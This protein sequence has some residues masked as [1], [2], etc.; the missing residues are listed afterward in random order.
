MSALQT[1]ASG[2]YEGTKTA[3][4]KHA[5]AYPAIKGTDPQ[6][7]LSQESLEGGARA[8]GDDGSP[9]SARG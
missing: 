7:T 4:Q 6:K 3:A 5:E 1:S 9:T 8:G 2:N